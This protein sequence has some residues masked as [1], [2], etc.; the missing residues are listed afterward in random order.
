MSAHATER[1]PV[2]VIEIYRHNP[3]AGELPRF[4]KYHLPFDPGLTVLD[5]L[6]RI[7]A[8][9]DPTLAFRH[10]CGCSYCGVCAIRMNGRSVLAC[11]TL[12]EPYMK[13]EPLNPSRVIRD[14]VT[15]WPGSRKAGERR[16]APA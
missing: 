11:K 7:Y 3:A 9:Q 1:D 14:L 4:Q 15:E 10:S 16:E 12:M 13:L 6:K 2:A 5:V 8:D